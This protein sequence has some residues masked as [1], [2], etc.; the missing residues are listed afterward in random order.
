MPGI[1]ETVPVAS[2][3]KVARQSAE[4]QTSE[5]PKNVRRRVVPPTAAEWVGMGFLAVGIVR[6]FQR[7]MDRQLRRTD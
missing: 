7:I 5:G 4:A 1:F 2:S 3:T 6:I